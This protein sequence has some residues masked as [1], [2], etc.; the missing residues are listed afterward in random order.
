[1]KN[2]LHIATG[3]T[4]SSVDLGNGLQPGLS[5]EQLIN[6]CPRLKD[7]CVIDS[8]QLLKLD[9]TNI[10]PGHWIKIADCIKEN[11]DKYDGFVISHGTDTLAYTAS[12]LSYLVQDSNKPIVLTGA[13]KPIEDSNSD[14]I[15]NLTE[16]FI[17]ASDDKSVGVSV[18]FFD[19]VIAGTRARKNY[20]SSYYAFGSINF[21]ELARFNYELIIRYV[22]ED[23]TDGVKFYDYLDPNVGLIKLTPGLRK[24]VLEFL[25]EQYDGIIIESYGVGG[26]PE[27]SDFYET[28]KKAV[29][30]GKLIVMATQVPNDGSNLGTY[31]VGSNLKNN[32]NVLET[33]DMTSEAALTKLMWILGQTSEFE[34]AKKL[35]YKCI[36]HD[37]EYVEE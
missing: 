32:L 20:S 5:G 1:M 33:H 35:F 34:E 6:L 16:A 7:V 15:R 29:D 4:I 21:R 13:Q 23:K 18:V 37:I 17:Y 10:R 26:L 31:K 14:A 30:N 8:I 2:I 27:I 25:I 36:G 12:A 28:I 19:V 3:G 11:Y 22:K 9:S 24:D